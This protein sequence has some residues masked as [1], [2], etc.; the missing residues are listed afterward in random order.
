MRPDSAKLGAVQRD[1]ATGIRAQHEVALYVE[2]LVA[3]R[4]G[5]TTVA[6]PHVECL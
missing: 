4:P 3:E 1:P 6:I 5:Q 2:L